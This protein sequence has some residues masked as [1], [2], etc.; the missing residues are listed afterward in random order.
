[1]IGREVWLG[2]N[3]ADLVAIE[4]TG[5]PCIIEVKLA[6]NSE[7]RRAVVAQV[8]SYAACLHGMT[9][10]QAETDVFAGPL[11]RRGFASLM[12]A[13]E[14]AGQ[15]GSFDRDAFT[16]TLDDALEHGA[17]R[18]VLVLDEAPAELI[19][20]VGFLQAVAPDLTVDLVTVTAYQ[21]GERRVLVPQRVEPSRAAVDRP[22]PPASGGLAG[23]SIQGADVFLRSINDA[24][25][26]QQP[27]LRRLAQ[28][29]LELQRRGLATLTSYQ[30][31]RGEVTLLPKIKP[32][33]VGLVTIWN[34][35]GTAP[36]Q[37]WKSVFQR[38]APS[39]LPMVE[40]AAAPVKVG[41]GNTITEVND[42]LLACLTQA[43]EEAG[44]E[45]APRTATR[46]PDRAS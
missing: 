39:T 44:H 45:G 42:D 15:D 2:G 6:A 11:T 7:A 28:W 46:V 29:A 12:E 26:E 25:A 34:W 31:A 32:D 38:R 35:N 13:A 40:G 20:T 33:N 30:G 36:L 3:K 19:R 22:R 18:L 9:A 16:A 24:P 4:A 43:Y 37:F 17:F 41:Q 23:S 27:T 10:D 1:V 21:V 8:L 5:R 14:Q